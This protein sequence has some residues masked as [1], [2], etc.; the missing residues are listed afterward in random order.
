VGF[1]EMDY[2]IT[3]ILRQSGKGQ[4]EIEQNERNRNRYLGRKVD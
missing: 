4:N 3:R 1:E 2:I